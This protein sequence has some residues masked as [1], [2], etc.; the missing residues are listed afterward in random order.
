M[1]TGDRAKQFNHHKQLCASLP[2]LSLKFKTWPLALAASVS[3]LV[4]S[5]KVHVWANTIGWVGVWRGEN[6][7]SWSD[8]IKTD[9]PLSPALTSTSYES[10]G[11]TRRRRRRGW[12]CTSRSCWATG[13]TPGRSSAGV[14]WPHKSK[15]AWFLR[16]IDWNFCSA[17]MKHGVEGNPDDFTLS[18]LLPDKGTTISEVL[19]D[20]A[21]TQNYARCKTWQDLKFPLFQSCRFPPKPTSTTRSTRNT[22]STSCW[23]GKPLR[24]GR[25]T[26]WR[27]PPLRP[28]AG[29]G[30]PRRL[31]G[32]SLDLPSDLLSL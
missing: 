5:D 19:E 16:E 32:N 25:L 30:T 2:Q 1:R 21:C 3:W 13:S 9:F 8:S 6:F 10:R 4:Q 28:Q 14:T 26:C 22:T 27:A 18:Q 15:T 24:R 23:R 12:S 11:V 20:E 7:I 17:M 29:R 31:A